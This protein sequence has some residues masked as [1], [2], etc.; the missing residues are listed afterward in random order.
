MPLIPGPSAPP[1]IQLLRWIRNPSRLL[2]ECQARFGDTFAIRLP[3]LPRQFV[4]LAAPEAIREVFAM[5][6]DASHAGKANGILRPFLGKHSLLLLD[7]AEHL[8]QRKMMMPAFH[9]ERMHAYGETMMDLAHQSLDDWPI[10]RAFPVHR[11]LQWIALQVILRTV[12]GVEP[13]PRHARLAD[14]LTRGLEVAG[15]PLL[16]LPVVQR[17]LGRFSPWGRYRRLA[18]HAS[19][20]LRDEIRRGRTGGTSGRTDILALLLDARDESGRALDEDEVHDELMTLLVA[21]HETTA[22]ALA[23]ALRW[24]LDDAPLVARLRDEIASAQGDPAKVAKLE[25]LDATVKETL[26]LQPVIALVG[27]VLQTGARIGGIDFPAGTAVAPCIYLVHRRASLYPDPARF[28]PD[29]FATFKP[30]PWEWIPFGGGLRRCIGAAFATYEMKMVLAS[31][32]P[33]VDAR[34]ATQRVA[35]ARRSVTITPSGGLPI[36]VTA[37]RPRAEKNRAA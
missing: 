22:T 31:V 15:Q 4:V 16:M 12:F 20:L 8:R 6:S 29:R 14:A 9:G 24:L 17:D 30:S 13:G 18:S 7:G 37:R 23:W 5:S 34:L 28:A 32:L 19:A 26:R 35:P 10:G 11:S 27:R 2:S 1:A 25:L 36:V 3:G 21:G 33:R